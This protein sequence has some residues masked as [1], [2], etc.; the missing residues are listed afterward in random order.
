MRNQVT[1]FVNHYAR[2]VTTVK[3]ETFTPAKNQSHNFFLQV[4]KL[5]RHKATTNIQ[6]ILGGHYRTAPERNIKLSGLWA[7]LMRRNM[8]LL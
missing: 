6:R 4:L 5:S 3:R 1:S 8:S 7:T 2:L